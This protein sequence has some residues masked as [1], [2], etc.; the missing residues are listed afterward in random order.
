MEK[1]TIGK[2]IAVLR[3][4]QNLTQCS[5]A[6]KIG[7]TDRAVSK[8]ENGRGL[9]DVSCMK[10]LCE[11]LEISVDELLSGERIPEE[12]H[13]D[14]NKKNIMELLLQRE[15]EIRKRRFTEKLC[16]V[17]LFVVL[18]LGCI[19]LAKSI[20]LIFSSLRGEGETF[21][22]SFYTQKAEKVCV[23]IEREQW[24]KA[25]EYI[26][27]AGQD[28]EKGKTCFIK[29]MQLLT[30]EIKIE[31]MIVSSIVLEDC[32]PVGMYTINV[33]DMKSDA[34][35]I[36]N[37]QLTIQSKGIAFGNVYISEGNTDYRRTEVA[38]IINAALCT[39]Y[40]G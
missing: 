33:T 37:G 15:L 27:F 29:N 2:F 23:L 18:I 5:L 40:A 1:K 9:P 28:K 3:K 25:S 11:I 24:E 26:G 22:T 21:Y 13:V 10:K 31:S 4:E 16:A 17:M 30:D 35:Y 34:Q 38:A 32:F 12:E 19:V 7:V 8:W 14:V 20:G 6:E 36:F 39:W